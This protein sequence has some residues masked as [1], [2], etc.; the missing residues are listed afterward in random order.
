MRNALFMMYLL[1]L[2]GF[3]NEWSGLSKVGR[4]VTIHKDGALYYL[5][6]N[7][8]GARGVSAKRAGAV[9]IEC[10]IEFMLGAI[11]LQFVAG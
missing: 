7:L 4:L 3:Q 9:S 11:E 8:V 6:L 2:F 10:Y 5:H 1:F